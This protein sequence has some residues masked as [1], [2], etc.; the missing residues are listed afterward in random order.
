MGRAFGIGDIVNGHAWSCFSAQRSPPYPRCRAISQPRVAIVKVAGSPR[1]QGSGFRL[2]PLMRTSVRLHFR[3][4]RRHG[5]RLPDGPVARLVW[6]SF[7]KSAGPWNM[8]IRSVLMFSQTFHPAIGGSG[9]AGAGDLSAGRAGN[10]GNG[11]YG[12]ARRPPGAGKY[13]GSDREAPFGLRAEGRWI[14]WC[15]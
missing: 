7:P 6:R 8:N 3:N 15:S 5:V 1:E 2:T 9:K 14:R 4:R 13:R 11:A 10:K 12:A